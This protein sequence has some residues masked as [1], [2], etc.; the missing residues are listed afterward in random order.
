MQLEQIFTPR[1][2]AINKTVTPSDGMPFLL[3][4]YW[5]DRKKNGLSLDWMR[6]NKGLDAVLKTS[7]F[8]ATPTIRPRGEV[9]VTHEEMPLFRESKQIRERDLMMIQEAESSESRYVDE[10]LDNM[11]DDTNELLNGADIAAEKM[12]GQLI[13]GNGGTIGV[14]IPMNDNMIHTYNYDPDGSWKSEHYVELATT[15]TWDKPDAAAPLDDIQTG[16]DYLASIGVVATDVIATSYTWGLFTKCKQVKDALITATGQEVN[17]MNGKMSK[18]VLQDVLGVGRISYD[19]MYKDYDS[20]QK[21]FYPDGYVT[22]LGS[23]QLGNTWRGTTAEERT[24]LGN[25]LANVYVMENGV[26]VAIKTEQGPPVSITTTVS[27]I[28]LPSFEG[29]DSIFVIKVA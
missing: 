29:M 4:Q 28:V 24:L 16:I 9:A 27:Q 25:P 19:K 14:S 15:D 7:S 1:T 11:Y 20:V 18:V 8:D 26:A 6:I 13:S 21:K 10:A 22:I 5:P 23:G 12:R 2:I 17:F 3:N